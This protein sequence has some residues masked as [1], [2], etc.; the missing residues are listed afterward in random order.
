[1]AHGSRFLPGMVAQ[2]KKTKTV[3]AFGQKSLVVGCCS[4]SRITIYC[5]SARDDIDKKSHNCDI[6]EPA[7]SRVRL[8]WVMLQQLG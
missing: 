8:A 1:M 2:Q 5:T 4:T 7:K 3:G 6:E